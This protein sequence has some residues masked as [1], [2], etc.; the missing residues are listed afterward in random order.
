MKKYKYKKH[1]HLIGASIALAAASYISLHQ[2]QTLSAYINQPEP[3]L[4]QTMTSTLQSQPITY[5]NIFVTS[6]KPGAEIAREVGLSNTRFVITF[7]RL[8]E[9]HIAKNTTIVIPSELKNWDALSPFPQTLESAAS[10]PQLLLVSQ[11]VQ[12]IAAYEYGKRVRWMVTSTGKKDTPTPSKLYFTNWKGKLV[13]SSVKDE[14]ILPWYFNLDNME[15]ISLHQYEL[16]GYPASHSCVRLTEAD[17]EWIYNWAKQW[18]LASDGNTKLASG[19]PVIVFGSYQYGKTAPWKK[20]ATDP[21]A[22]T[23]TQAELDAIVQTYLP[24]IQQKAAQRA[25]LEEAR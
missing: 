7:N 21:T 25:A 24:E 23:L 6:S 3:V 12:A 10:I 19:T 14:W 9:K 13:V 5:R 16:P 20:L 17:A 8:D 1:I 11:R 15:G 22:T 2:R 4:T 18:I